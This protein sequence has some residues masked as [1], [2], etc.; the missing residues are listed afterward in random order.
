M[1]FR[2]VEETW[3]GAEVGLEIFNGELRYRSGVYLS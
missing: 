1:R 2:S 3:V